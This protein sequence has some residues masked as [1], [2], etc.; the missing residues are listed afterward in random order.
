[1]ADVIL[2]LHGIIGRHAVHLCHFFVQQLQF[3]ALGAVLL[4]VHKFRRLRTE[5]R[6]VICAYGCTFSYTRS[7][8]LPKSLTLRS[9][10][11]N[12]MS[13]CSIKPPAFSTS[14]S[15]PKPTAITSLAVKSTLA[16]RTM[17]RVASTG[18]FV[19][20]MIVA[21]RFCSTVSTACSDSD[22]ASGRRRSSTV[23]APKHMLLR[24]RRC[25]CHHR[26]RTPSACSSA[27]PHP[28]NIP[29]HSHIPFHRPLLMV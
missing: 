1:M 26:L 14:F 18:L 12:C 22:F 24:H 11:S 17:H 9:S 2:L 28:T 3:I 20:P 16:Y 13:F 4:L 23:H 8:P 25:R 19:S 6:T 15:T 29:A 10:D 7:L 21:G 5:Q 27:L